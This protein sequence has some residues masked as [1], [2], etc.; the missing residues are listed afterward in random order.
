[1][2]AFGRSSKFTPLFPPLCTAKHASCHTTEPPAP[3]IVFRSPASTI[4]TPVSQTAD[5]IRWRCEGRVT[6][7]RGAPAQ[8]TLAPT[9]APMRIMYTH[10]HSL[11]NRHLVPNQPY[12][13]CGRKAPCLFTVPHELLSCLNVEVAALGSPSLIVLVNVKQH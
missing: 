6:G 5:G 4:V 7:P 11:L 1:M 12:G 10:A 2:R 9:S 3:G 8:R 13:F